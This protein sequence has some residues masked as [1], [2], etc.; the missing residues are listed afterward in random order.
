ML[1]RGSFRQKGIVHFST[2]SLQTSLFFFS[3]SQL[4]KKK[5]MG[6]EGKRKRRASTE[7]L[8]TNTGMGNKKREWIV[9]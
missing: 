4:T 8:I 3:T 2:S 5:K 6:R 7:S 9:G 1:E